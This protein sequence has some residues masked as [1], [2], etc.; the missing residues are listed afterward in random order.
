MTD[1]AT[2]LQP[3]NLSELNGETLNLTYS[4]LNASPV[5]SA[6]PQS[7]AN[8]SIQSPTLAAVPEAMYFFYDN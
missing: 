8:E 7:S 5:D 1:G 4:V 3:A 6:P 2:N